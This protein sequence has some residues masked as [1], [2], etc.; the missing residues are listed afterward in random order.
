MLRELPA[1]ERVPGGNMFDD[2]K[3]MMDNAI[4][5]NDALSHIENQKSGDSQPHL[6]RNWLVGVAVVAIG[7]A[8]LI[9][10]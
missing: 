5:H 1:S 6:L 3:N 2:A 4:S 9:I 10:F 8:L 7:I